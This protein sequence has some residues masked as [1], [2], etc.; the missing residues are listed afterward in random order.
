M[1]LALGLETRFKLSE[2]CAHV[3]WTDRDGQII[4]RSLK[5]HAYFHNSLPVNPIVCELNPVHPDT[6]SL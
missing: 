4:L 2:N 1:C 3:W 6:R 5:V